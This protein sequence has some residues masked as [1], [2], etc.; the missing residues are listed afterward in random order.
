MKDKGDMVQLTDGVEAICAFFVEN[1]INLRRVIQ[2]M[3]H[4]NPTLD[5]LQMLYAFAVNRNRKVDLANALLSYDSK[6]RELPQ[7]TTGRDWFCECDLPNACPEFFLEVR[8]YCWI[9]SAFESS[10]FDAGDFDE[11]DS[12]LD[13]V[14][15]VKK[16]VGDGMIDMEETLTRIKLKRNAIIKAEKEAAKRDEL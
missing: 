16:N 4:G 5:F 6:C 3:P 1:P 12:V 11:V 15:M 9:R 2:L 13:F 10:E 8:R 7:I 14:K